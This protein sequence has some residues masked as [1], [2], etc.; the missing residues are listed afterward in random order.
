MR[1]HRPS[2]L[3]A[4]ATIDRAGWPGTTCRGPGQRI[5]YRVAHS[6]GPILRPSPTGCRREFCKELTIKSLQSICAEPSSVLL[7]AFGRP[8][9]M[10]FLWSRVSRSRR[11]EHRRECRILGLRVSGT[12][13]H[14][15]DGDDDN[16]VARNTTSRTSR[17]PTLYHKPIC[18]PAQPR[19][20]T[21]SS[22]AS[23][24]GSTSDL[25]ASSATGSRP[26]RCS[27]SPGSRFD[28]QRCLRHPR[29]DRRS[30]DP[31]RQSD[32]H[33]TADTA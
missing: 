31:C 3:A 25:P 24:K 5:G 14:N 6:T 15:D 22:P 4:H 17:C 33:A 26:S 20:V 2:A 30:R 8:A 28:R 27:R 19:L 1:G 16:P 9:E 23:C 13:D 18:N 10:R 21:P 32:R 12:R 7:L 29:H 11:A